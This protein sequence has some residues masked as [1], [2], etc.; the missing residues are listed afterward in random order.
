MMATSNRLL[1]L[2]K[3]II[4]SSNS[5]LIIRRSLNMMEVRTGKVAGGEVAETAKEDPNMIKDTRVRVIRDK[6]DPQEE[7][8]KR[9][10]TNKEI[11]KTTTK[12]ITV[13]KSM[14]TKVTVQGNISLNSKIKYRMNLGKMAIGPKPQVEQVK[15]ERVNTNLKMRPR[16]PTKSV[17]E[18]KVASISQ[19]RTMAP[20]WVLKQ[21]QTPRKRPKLLYNRLR[22]RSSRRTCLPFLRRRSEQFQF[23]Q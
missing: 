19:R 9:V 21:E 14:L 3:R 23:V 22:E 12:K 4:K 2:F 5:S 16:R 7:A 15:V 10:T 1:E 18:V 20:F 13:N 8:T 6:R 11:T 17:R